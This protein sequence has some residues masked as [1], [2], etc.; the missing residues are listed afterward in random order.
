MSDPN[1]RPVRRL[2]AQPQQTAPS[3]GGADP[4][5]RQGAQGMTSDMFGRYMEVGPDGRIDLD[6]EVVIAEFRRRGLLREGA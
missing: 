3:L 2:R 1:T 5:H 6:I 4:R